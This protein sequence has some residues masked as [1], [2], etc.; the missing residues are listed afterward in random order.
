MRRLGGELKLG[1]CLPKGTGGTQWPPNLA[2]SIRMARRS[3]CSHKELRYEFVMALSFFQAGLDLQTH[4]SWCHWCLNMGA[5][6]CRNL[7]W[8]LWS[9]LSERALLTGRNTF[10]QCNHFIFWK[11]RWWL[12]S[13]GW[14]GLQ[15]GG[16][17]CHML[18]DVCH[19][20]PCTSLVLGSRQLNRE[21]GGLSRLS[22][23]QFVSLC[24]LPSY[25]WCS[26]TE[27]EELSS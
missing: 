10:L 1:V 23:L 27:N 4:M 22:A 14:E 12:V 13:L 3:S 2:G 8:L 7:W 17:G 19:S 20:F 11:S 26:N 15:R 16:C 9:A 6:A 21:A 25:I 18:K 24:P 5:F